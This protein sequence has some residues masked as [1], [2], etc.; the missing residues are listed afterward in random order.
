[1]QIQKGL[2]KYKDRS[3]IV[4][5]YG[6][7]DDGKQYYFLDNGTLSNGNIIATTVLVEAIDPVVAAS[8]VGVIDANGIVVI[9]FEN[10][11]IKSIIDGLLLVEVS[12]STTPSVVEAVGLKKDPLAATKLVTTS[13]AIKEKINTKMGADGRFIFNDQFSEATIFDYAGNNLLDNKYFSFIAIKNNETLYLCG[14]TTESSVL[15][16]SLINRMF[17]ANTDNVPLDIQSTDVTQDTIDGAMNASERVIG[18]NAS[19]ITEKD[20]EA[21]A[22]DEG[23]VEPVSV[24]SSVVNPDEDP[25]EE[26]VDLADDNTEEATLKDETGNEFE[27]PLP[28]IPDALAADV[29]GEKIQ[30]NDDEL[31]YSDSKVTEVEST[32]SSEVIEKEIPDEN[33]EVTA[34]ESINEETTNLRIDNGTVDE[35]VSD[36]LM[37]FDFEDG[38][39]YDSLTDNYET[40]DLP[41]EDVVNEF[42]NDLFDTDLNSDIFADSK[43]E[44]D[45]IDIASDYN[46]KFG[47]SRSSIIEDVTSTMSN[48]IN[49]NRNQRDTIMA[50]ET[51]L[52]QAADAYK[53]VVEKARSQLRDVEILKNKLKNY[54]TIVTKLEGKLQVL[55]NKVH[56]QD[57]VI[58]NQSREL[59][60]LRPQVEGKEE[61]VRILAD[62]QN[63]LEQDI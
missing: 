43:F 27:E 8:S 10:K 5:T 20:F 15:E 46:Y 13:A 26:V 38:I 22:I 51:K 9:P 54:E 7:T 48:L 33:S 50:Y 63:L 49:Q 52:N 35:K 29:S 61:L 58:T 34:E 2:V 1:M 19:D 31:Q 14:N 42:K 11:S 55:E 39:N 44:V 59:E 25:A 16:Y 18:F 32:D 37:A 41:V 30:N 57:K 53:N 45:K 60:A 3:D 62:A 36:N 21:V 12:N 28:V 23:V 6:L 24:E 56:D 4:C 40:T 47:G 17:I